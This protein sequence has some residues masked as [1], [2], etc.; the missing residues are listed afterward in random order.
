MKWLTIRKRLFLLVGFIGGCILFVQCPK[1]CSHSNL[2]SAQSQEST[3]QKKSKKD[4]LRIRQLPSRSAHYVEIT[5]QPSNTGTELS[6]CTITAPT[7]VG[8]G[9]L[10]AAIDKVKGRL[11][12]TLSL[13][14]ETSLDKVYVSQGNAEVIKQGKPIKIKGA[15]VDY[16]SLHHCFKVNN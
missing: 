8:H 14:E 12:Y 9:V 16:V 10:F 3:Q 4:L 5:I 7:L 13:A 11:Q 15:A 6:Q 1:T 2:P